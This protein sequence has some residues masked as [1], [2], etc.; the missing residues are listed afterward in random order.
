MIRPFV[1][2]TMEMPVTLQ[3]LHTVAK[4]FRKYLIT[5]FQCKNMDEQHLIAVKK[6]RHSSHTPF[7]N[8][9][10]SYHQAH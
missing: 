1:L 10:K 7:C 6:K 5:I 4:V 9:S 8:K 2:A 3:K